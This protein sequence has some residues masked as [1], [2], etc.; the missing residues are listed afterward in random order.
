MTPYI[1]MEKRKMLAAMKCLAKPEITDWKN[2]IYMSSIEMRKE[3]NIL[4][5]G[6]IILFSFYVFDAKIKLCTHFEK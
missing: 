5:S 3:I 2:L 1:D 4:D 6:W